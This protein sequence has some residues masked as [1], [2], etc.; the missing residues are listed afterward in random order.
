[1]GRGRPEDPPYRWGSIPISVL[2][3]IKLWEA[4]SDLDANVKKKIFTLSWTYI[5]RSWDAEPEYGCRIA[6]INYFY[7]DLSTFKPREN[8]N[9]Q[10][11]KV[12]K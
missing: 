12:D 3:K 10:I 6:Q 9:Y 4:D 7:E 5:D 1:M 11:K 8:R 2:P